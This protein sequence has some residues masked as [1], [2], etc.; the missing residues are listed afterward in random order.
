MFKSLKGVI[1]RPLFGYHSA[2]YDKSIITQV[3]YSQYQQNELA[4]LSGTSMAVYTQHYK[5]EKADMD[6]QLQ[7]N[8]RDEGQV[9][10]KKDLN[11][12]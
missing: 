1:L 7:S 6:K 3:F 10:T 8:C 12:G 5:K 4:M 2:A 11:G 9:Q